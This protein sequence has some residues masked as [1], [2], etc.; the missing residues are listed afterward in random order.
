[1][2]KRTHFLSASAWHGILALAILG[3]A[4]APAAA[5]SSNPKLDAYAGIPGAEKITGGLLD[6]ALTARKTKAALKDVLNK[7]GS[8]NEYKG[9]TVV[10]LRV[11]NTGPALL[12][13]IAGTGATI[14]STSSKYSRVTVT[15]TSPDTVLKLGAIPE[16]GLITPVNRPI[17]RAG[18]VLSG[19]EAAL[20]VDTARFEFQ[21]GLGKL[22]DGAG[23]K[24]GILSDSCSEERV[25]LSSLTG[26]LPP[27]GVEILADTPGSDE[28]AAMAELVHDV[29]PGAD[30]VFHTAFIS[31]S[32]FADG[33]I[34]L[35]Q[36]GSTVIV[37]DVIYFAEP[38]YMNGIVA[39]SAT[40]VV[41]A[42]IPYFSAAGNFGNDALQQKYKDNNS[43]QDEISIPSTGKDLHK[44][45]NGTGFYPVTVPP[46][47]GFFAYLH[48]NQPDDIVVSDGV[49]IIGDGSQ[50]DFDLFVA[51]SANQA[52]L[53]E[54]YTPTALGDGRASTDVQGDIGVGF[55]NPFET[56]KFYNPANTP[57][58]AYVVID[59]YRGAKGNI[60]QGNV[61][62]EF[63]LIFNR[64]GEDP[65]GIVFQG[66]NPNDN[67]TGGPTIWGHS[68]AEGAIS[69]GAARYIESPVYN[70]DSSFFGPT[71]EI[72]PEPFTARGGVT[73]IFFDKDGG[74]NPRTSFEP[75]MMCVDGTNTTFFGGGDFDVD[76]N[77]NFFGTSAAAP[78]AAAVAA[79][80]MELN[81][82]LSSSQ[83]IAAMSQSA[84]D[85]KGQRA[86]QGVDDVSGVG[87]IDALSTVVHISDQYGIVTN[88]LAENSTKFEFPLFNPGVFGADSEGWILE[89]GL[90]DPPIPGY[91]KPGF[92]DS[93]PDAGGQPYHHISIYATNNTNT[94]G[95]LKSPDLIGSAFVQNPE[96]DPLAVSGTTGKQSLYRA[97]FEV[98]AS[99]PDHATIPTF[100]IRESARSF[101]ESNM[102]VI[103]SSGN[104]SLS[105]SS[106]EV[107][108]YKHYFA[109]PESQ[110]RF[111]LYFDLLGVDSNDLP[112][113]FLN[114]QEVVLQGLST[115]NLSDSRLHVLRDFTTGTNGWTRRNIPDFGS[116]GGGSSSAGLE[117]GPASSSSNTCFGF[118][119]GPDS[120]GE[121][122]LE[123][124]RLYRAT[125]RIK[126]SATAAQITRV[127]T[128]RLRAN[129]SSNK[130]A[131]ITDVTSTVTTSSI[132]TD[133][134]T[135]DYIMYFQSPDE[136]VGNKVRFSFDY[137]F[138]PGIEDDPNL[139]ITLQSLR[140]D[141]YAPPTGPI[142]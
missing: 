41:D 111:N 23:Q 102:L 93:Q 80:A 73:N 92:S 72:D 12:K 77:L 132:P 104:G 96:N 1:M 44:W 125:F 54:I 16:V 58:T 89:P 68:V 123:V 134:A 135:Y 59:H 29:A 8:F 4:S 137:L 5:Q 46:R 133:G 128:F 20:R 129:D 106:N 83:V 48:W 127:P 32:D 37:D 79:L 116:V 69:V 105:P 141:S 121:V 57:T 84:W 42:G 21:D 118:W 27:D 86:K 76:G 114:I 82:S 75:D 100:R 109:L 55:G 99:S 71:A 101:E 25:T 62:L 140:I 119:S 130:L 47:S 67:S 13:E 95:W 28:G 138:V 142:S 52:G 110:A 14:V 117:L 22:L 15:V 90:A 26:D 81:P 9:A 64:A 3:T 70:Q 85:V 91:T 6:S 98:T 35:A 38:F 65:D 33:I 19:A 51:L 107:K 108:I 103:T 11:A 30:L 63:T 40:A 45:P 74:F 136:L 24:V 60:P 56:V 31:E 50:V 88:T 43:S 112:G 39:Q 126:T 17:T 34:K 87:L 49:S 122:T 115:G 61:P 131:V 78:N 94:L 53:D 139:K 7:R 113:V 36:A 10:E 97:T 18:S 66:I 120:G 2:K 124:N